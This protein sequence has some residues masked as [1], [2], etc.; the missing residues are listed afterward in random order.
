MARAVKP[1][2]GA[3]GAP[4]G[5]WLGIAFLF[6]CLLLSIVVATPAFGQTAAAGAARPGPRPLPDAPSVMLAEGWQL[7][8]SAG[9]EAK[10]AEVS[11]A[12]YDVAGWTAA[13]VPTTVLA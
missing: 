3:S 12:G 1:G 8:S 5:Y 4:V 13:R 11:R 9:L 2:P 7:R 6:T 10:G